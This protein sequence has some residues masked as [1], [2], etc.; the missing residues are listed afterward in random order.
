MGYRARKSCLV[1]G[2]DAIAR[3][4]CRNHYTQAHKHGEHGVY[5]KVSQD[6]AFDSRVE[7]TPNCWTWMGTRNT[8]GYG[9]FLLPGEKAVRAHRY[10][11]ERWKGPIPE[12]MVVMHSCDNPPCINPAHLSLGTKLDNNRDAASKRHT[13]SGDRHWMS[14][15]T[16]KQVA[17]IRADKGNQ[18]ELA[19]KLGI[20]QGTVSRIK[21]G[22]RRKV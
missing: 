1:C 22:K 4:L 11:Y 8:Y 18:T 19:A 3:S 10:A 20:T 15:L 6:E 17:Q 5:P 9:I 21:S 7:K 14:K 16:E 12:G 13:R 2:K